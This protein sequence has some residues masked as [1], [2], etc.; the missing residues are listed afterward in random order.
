MSL[1]FFLFLPVLNHK[2]NSKGKPAQQ[3][4]AKHDIKSFHC[5]SSFLSFGVTK[6][7]SMIRQRTVTPSTTPIENT[8]FSAS[9][10]PMTPTVRVYL[11]ASAKIL[12]TTLLLSLIMLT[13]LY[14]KEEAI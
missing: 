12:A 4:Y 1:L 3:N 2:I 9:I 7:A 8:N 10:L 5:H 13:K 14:H 11:A 6:Y